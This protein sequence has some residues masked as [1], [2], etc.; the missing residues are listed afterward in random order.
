M[1]LSAGLRLTAAPLDFEI[2]LETVIEHDDRKFL[3]YHPRPVSIPS[4]SRKPPTVLLTLQK[5]LNVSDYYSGLYT[6]VRDGRSGNWSGPTAIPELGWRTNSDGVTLA[7]ADVTPG[8]HPRS[9]KV[10]AIGCQV[11]YGKKG[12]Q[13]DE[14]PR[15]HQTAYAIHDPKTGSWTQWQ[16]LAIPTAR[17]FDFSRNACAQWLVE[18]NGNIL[19]PVYFGPNA[20]DPFSVTVVECSFNGRQL[21][22]LRHGDELTNNIQRGLVEPSLIGFKNRYY[23]TLRNDARGY[24]SSSPDGLR[25]D[26]L[27][28]WTFDDGSELGSYNT[29][30]HWIAHSDALFLIYTRRGASNDHIIRHRAPLFMAQV[31]PKKLQILRAT[32]K[33]LIPERGGEMGNFGAALIDEKESW[34]TVSEGIWSEEARR[35]G[36]KGATFV[37]RILWS[38]PNRLQK[39]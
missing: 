32:E 9:G 37:A 35:R 28:P 24:V 20:K 30:Q 25:W 2:R 14:R 10:L 39:K 38:R 11:P 23:L 12:E 21:N 4:P 15:Q 5:H 16:L 31:D 1:L 19:L 6:L 17:K 7:V 36:A 29:Q 27:Q 22:Y 18:K 34:V 26:P 13:L 8:F 33:I 3:W